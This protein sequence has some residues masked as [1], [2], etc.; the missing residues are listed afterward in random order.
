MGEF[1][2]ITE[3]IGVVRAG[4]GRVVAFPISE[5]SW[6]DIGEWAEYKRTL[7]VLGLA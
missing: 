5:K 2:H 4:G 6:C 1:Y 3:R 7:G